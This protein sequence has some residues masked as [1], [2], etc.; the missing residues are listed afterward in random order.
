MKPEFKDALEDT[1][2]IAAIKDDKGLLQCLGGD[3]RIIFVLYG[4]V[5]TIPG[6]VE[7]IKEAGKLAVVHIDLINGLHPR[8]IAVDFIHRYTR[9]DGIISTK[10]NLITRAKE[11]GM[12]TVMRFFVIDSMAFSTMERQI[13]S[14]HPDVIEMLPALM[15]K[16]IKKVVSFAHCPVIAGGLISDKEDVLSVLNSGATCI[17][18]T[19]PTVW[20]L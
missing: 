12:F 16:I 9:A 11:L 3:S 5:L 18:S 7:Q 20:F 14:V 1:P 2:I 6:I 8:E 4:D 13:R 10:A 17:S 19:N 15:P